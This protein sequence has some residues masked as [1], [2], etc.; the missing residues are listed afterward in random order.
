MRVVGVVVGWVR[1]IGCCPAAFHTLLREAYSIRGL[2]MAVFS[3]TFASS[4]LWD[5]YLGVMVPLIL[6]AW[7]GVGQRRRIAI[8]TFVVLATG[9]WIRLDAIPEYRLALVVS[10]IV[11]SVAI[12]TPRAS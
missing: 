6:W 12:V 8:A 5:H 11:C 3:L 1:A 9:L 7:P 10:L 2:V 4:T